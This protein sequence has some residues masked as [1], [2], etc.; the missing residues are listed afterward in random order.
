LSEAAV[1]YAFE[2]LEPSDPPVRDAAARMIAQAE[3]EVEQ[4]RERARAEG[5]AEGR[6]AGHADGVAEVSRAA[7]AL[8]RAVREIESLRVETVDA[9]E[10]DAIDLALE[11]AEKVLAGTLKA[12]PDTVIEVVRGA[13]RRISDRRS[14]TVLVNPADLDTVRAAIDELTARGSGIEL[15][16]LQ[17]EERVVVGGAIV[18][19]AEDEVDASVYTQLERAREVIE[20]SL[21]S[22]E[23]VA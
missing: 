4:L 17:S 10:H 13:L 11:L 5:Y 19:T 23:H 14:V 9:V 22:A 20:H 7:S 6:H 8:E 16:D 18:R 21:A 12:R 3:L 1:S 2:P 15:C